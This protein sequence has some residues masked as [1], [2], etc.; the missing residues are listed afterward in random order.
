[1]NVRRAVSVA[2]R[3]TGRTMRLLKDVGYTDTEIV[4]QLCADA[5]E[6]PRGLNPMDYDLSVSKMVNGRSIPD[7]VYLHSSPILHGETE[8][9]NCCERV[10]YL[11]STK[12]SVDKKKAIKKFEK[13]YFEW[14]LLKQKIYRLNQQPVSEE[15]RERLRSLKQCL[16]GANDNSFAVGFCAKFVQFCV[17][18]TRQWTALARIFALN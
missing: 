1:M 17:E 6:Y 12:L 15:L 14:R 3:Q 16:L 11:K 9:K 8:I 5:G 18:N 2:K 7:D 4:N 13:I 10:K